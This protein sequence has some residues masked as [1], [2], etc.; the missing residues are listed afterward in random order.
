MTAQTQQLLLA[1]LAICSPFVLSFLIVAILSPRYKALSER[2]GWTVQPHPEDHRDY[3]FKGQKDGVQWQM[4]CYVYE[5]Y[6]YRGVSRR[7]NPFTRVIVWTCPSTRLSNHTLLVFPRKDRLKHFVHPR[8]SLQRDVNLV[9]DRET[10]I[11]DRLLSHLPQITIGS[12]EFQELFV[13]DTDLEGSAAN[14]I[15]RLQFELLTWPKDRFAGPVVL[16]NSSGITIWWIPLGM[17][18]EYLEK[19]VGLGA[20]LARSLQHDLA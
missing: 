13:V 5:H 18:D 11:L 8:L 14:L 15:N 16:L 19:T 12:S 7:H 1:F 20:S 2:N 9:T 17:Q 4:E 6:R 3:L 10:E